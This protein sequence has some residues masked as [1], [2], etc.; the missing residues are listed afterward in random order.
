VFTNLELRYAME[1]CGVTVERIVD[2][3]YFIE[4]VPVFKEY[5]ETIYE[6]RLRAKAAGDQVRQ[7]TMKIFGNS[8]YGKPAQI[9]EILTIAPRWMRKEPQFEEYGCYAA[10]RQDGKPA[11]YTNFVWAAYITSGSRC[12]LHGHLVRLDALYCD[13]DSVYSY[14]K[15]EPTKELGALNYEDSSPYFEVL[16]PKT[17]K[18]KT[19]T[20]MKGIPADAWGAEMVKSPDGNWE[21]TFK[22]IHD[23]ERL[24]KEVFFTEVSRFRGAIRA[25]ALPNSWG[26]GEKTLRL[27]P[28]DRKRFFYADGSSRPLTVEEVRAIK[29]PWAGVV[30][31]PFFKCEG[32]IRVKRRKQA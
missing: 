8:L 21:F 4:A 25:G 18:T 20:R 12:K 1:H 29:T 27:Y 2:S 11:I 6:E 23:M 22:P 3:I 28:E 13:T 32:E 9:G 17:Y 26:I 16:G 31:L 30:E 15:V 7:Y 24:P 10:R 5:V 19:K 14:T